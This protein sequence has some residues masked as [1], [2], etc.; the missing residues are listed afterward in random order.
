MRS[1]NPST[2]SKYKPAWQAF[3]L[4]LLSY[5]ISDPFT[6]TNATI[7]SLYVTHLIHSANLRKIGPAT[8]ENAISAIK[9]FMEIAGKP[10]LDSPFITRLRLAAGRLLNPKRSACEPISV[11]DLYHIL[12]THLT[13]NCSL[14]TRMH[15]TVFLLMFIGLLRFN[16][17]QQIMVHQDCLRFIYSDSNVLLGCLIFIPFS[18]T[19]QSGDGV[20][21]AVGATGKRFCP[22]KLLSDLLVAGQYCTAPPEGHFAGP[23]LRPVI[24]KHKPA[25]MQLAVTTSSSPILPLTYPAFRSSLIAFSACLSK[26]F[27]LHSFRKG[28]ASTAAALSMDSRLICGLGR[29]K[30][31]TT[32]SDT[33]IKMMHGNMLKFFDLTRQLWP[34]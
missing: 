2:F 32:F 29:W 9:F 1:V 30:Q 16:D 10:I 4:W 34:Y 22:A 26:H 25:R 11:T 28:G 6:A 31:G 18:K 33:Y 15:L 14:R 8:I 24:G 13:P 12:S 3:Q 19:D 21:I 27:G 17:V 5:S 20:W 7:V 23:L